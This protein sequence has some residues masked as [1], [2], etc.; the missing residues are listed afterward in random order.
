MIRKIISVI[1]EYWHMDGGVAFGVVPKGIWNKLYPADENNNLSIVNRL[2]LVETHERLLLINAGFGNKRPERYYQFKYFSKKT[3]LNECILNAGYRPEDIS[4]VVFTHLHDDHCGGATF[5]NTE[6]GHSEPLFPNANFWIS[7]QQWHWALNPNPREAASYFPD[8]LLPLEKSG[9]L[10]LLSPDEQPFAD[11]NIELR[12]FD[13][14]TSGQ[15]I[16]L[17]RMNG[18][19]YVYISDFIPSS[20]HIP[21]PYIAAVDIQPLITLKEKESFLMEA[22]SEGYVIVFEHDAMVEACKVVLT[23]KGFQS[24]ASG[25]LSS[26]F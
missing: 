4:D 19:T 11:E 6:T 20:V 14:H 2:L 18:K 10:K 24:A 5:L 26:F 7:E 13:G 12:H 15:M 23:D 8:N 22:A 25:F 1:P 9:K 3:S 17:M 16:P 21:L